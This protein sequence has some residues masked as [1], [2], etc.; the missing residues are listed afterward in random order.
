MEKITIRMGKDVIWK[1]VREYEDDLARWIEFVSA[2]SCGD[3]G[4]AT[5]N[6]Q[7]VHTSTLFRH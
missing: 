6:V 5:A 1:V 2:E 3:P 7:K 4:I